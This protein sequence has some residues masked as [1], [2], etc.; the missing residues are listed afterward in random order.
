MME[1]TIRAIRRVLPVEQASVFLVDHHSGFMRSFNAMQLHDQGGTASAATVSIPIKMGLAGA[2]V[3][4]GMSEIVA[5]AQ[6]D[7]R[8][9]RA[10]DKKTGFRTRNVL[11][12]PVLL[13]SSELGQQ[14]GNGEA[15]RNVVD[16]T[17]QEQM[18]V[19]VLQ[20]LNRQHEFTSHDISV[21]E[22]L[23]SLISGV[24]ARSSLIE[25]AVRE[26]HRASSLL[27]CSETLYSAHKCAVK[28]FLVMRAA[29][30]GLDCDRISLVVV[31]QVHVQQVLIAMD[32]GTAGKRFPLEMGVVGV[33]IAKGSPVMMT[34]AYADERFDS[35][36]D[37]SSGYKTRDILAV[38]VIRR[39]SNPPQVLG[40]LEALN[41]SKGFDSSDQE[42]LTSVALQVADRLMP[43]LIQ[44][45]VQA[46]LDDHDIDEV[47]VLR[48]RGKLM[49]EFA[50]SPTLRA[51]REATKVSELLELGSHVGN[52]AQKS[53]AAIGSDGHGSLVVGSPDEEVILHAA[54]AQAHLAS[55]GPAADIDDNTPASVKSESAAAPSRSRSRWSIGGGRKAVP[56]P[57]V[58]G[59]GPS[60]LARGHI[61]TSPVVVSD[62][63]LAREG[64]LAAHPAPAPAPTI[65]TGRIDIWP[66]AGAWQG[67]LF[68]DATDSAESSIKSQPALKGRSLPVLGAHKLFQTPRAL[69]ADSLISWDINILEFDPNECMQLAAQVFHESGVL[70]TFSISCETLGNFL[71]AIGGRYH[72]NPYHNFN[73][74]C[75]V[76]LAAWLFVKEEL[77]DRSTATHS[78][79]GE[80]VGGGGDGSGG[81]G[82]FANLAAAATSDVA[83]AQTS[84]NEQRGDETEMLSQ[85][86]ILSLLVAAVSHDVDHPGITNAFLVNSGAALALRYNDNSVLESH[87]AATTFA[88]LQAQR[89]NMLGT[90]NDGDRREARQLIIGAI[91]A[92]DMARHP[93][94]VRDLAQ[95][96]TER[97]QGTPAAFKVSV[98][99]H[100]ADLCNCAIRW[101]LSQEWARRVCAEATAQ[102]IREQDLGLAPDKVTPYTDAELAARQLVFLDG[103]VRPLFKAAA[104]HY[105]GAR[106]RLHAVNRCREACKEELRSSSTPMVA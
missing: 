6:Q 41:S 75:H 55:T 10:V 49:D 33:V 29:C 22:L 100:M 25:A 37:V 65:F 78:T 87:H 13:K 80:G 12:V 59:Q 90:L 71:A 97:T 88:I 3:S 82:F 53:I 8:F 45:M 69:P 83:R 92:T 64:E 86:Q 9:N 15:N 60:A 58:A 77:L 70:D 96:A 38:P 72:N 63:S 68:G 48:L 50:Y 17:S 39:G 105:P 31:D 42:L 46:T 81:G 99:T 47:E 5:D 61:S 36:R 73:H 62:G 52:I 40:V 98:I 24:L 32:D 23:A 54:A 102:A 66:D 74:G 106:G 44:D 76:L 51:E 16:G 20:A 35:T 79:D 28:A 85:L 26:K 84:R 7:I 95:H 67:W 1:H 103:W 43:E 93:Q 2:V 89:C 4:S 30:H 94:I 104:I 91:M 34:D 56:K 21:L 18:V 27:Q 57:A 14:D 11:S 101:E 19:A